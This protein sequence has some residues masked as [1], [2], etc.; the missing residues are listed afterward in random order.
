MAIGVRL[1]CMAQAIDK[2]IPAVSSTVFI[3]LS[4]FPVSLQGRFVQNLYLQFLCKSKC[5]LFG[6]RM[7]RMGG[8]NKKRGDPPTLPLAFFEFYVVYGVFQDG[9]QAQRQPFQGET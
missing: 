5:S 9:W 7:Q 4:V 3:G 2:K 8:K 1:Q 6:F